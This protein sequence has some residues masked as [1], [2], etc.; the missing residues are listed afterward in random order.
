M[1]VIAHFVDSRNGKRYGPGDGNKIS[2]VLDPDQVV[3]L[4]AAKCIADGDEKAA[5][6]VPTLEKM[7]KE[8][9]IALADLHKVTLAAGAT[10]DDIIAALKAAKVD[11]V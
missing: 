5:A 1:K 6:P 9:L 3:R 8:D 2:P 4:T 7:K 10:K 11:A